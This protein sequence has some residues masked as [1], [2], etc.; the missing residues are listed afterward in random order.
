[1]GLVGYL[2]AFRQVTLCG[3][4]DLV[5]AWL[6]AVF[7]NDWLQSAKDSSLAYLNSEMEMA[8]QRVGQQSEI[9]S[10]FQF[11]ST[12]KGMQVETNFN[13]FFNLSNVSA[14]YLF[15]G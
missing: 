7:N 1:M 9:R 8:T 3:Q 6:D 10:R 5:A 14:A 11:K 12:M 13:F 4:G 2:D 15:S